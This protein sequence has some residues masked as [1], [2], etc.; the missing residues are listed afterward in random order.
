MKLYTEITQREKNKGFTP[1]PI[2]PVNTHRTRLV[3]GFT[4][5]E[6]L[7]VI[8]IIGI[9]AAVLLPSLNNA[10]AKALDARKIA[11]VNGIRPEAELYYDIG[12]TYAGMCDAPPNAHSVKIYELM[13]AAGVGPDSQCGANATVYAV[14]VQLSAGGSNSVWYCID[15]TGYAGK[16]VDATEPLITG[17]FNCDIDNT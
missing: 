10:R 17:D 4:L 5:I 8:A 3:S 15:S 16:T 2:S 13:V 7:I 12:N 14:K 1:T 11:E 6:L 9:L